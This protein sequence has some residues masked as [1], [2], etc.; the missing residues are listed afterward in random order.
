M[1]DIAHELYGAQRPNID[2]TSAADSRHSL[3]RSLL[4][5]AREVFAGSDATT[6]AVAE[7]QVVHTVAYRISVIACRIEVVFCIALC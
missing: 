6:R 5:F 7:A 2:A 4:L 3:H 1:R